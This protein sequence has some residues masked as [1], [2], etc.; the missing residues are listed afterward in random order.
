MSDAA[1]FS[2]SG[3]ND[4]GRRVTNRDEPRLR[5]VGSPL[6]AG[7]PGPSSRPP[8]LGDERRLRTAPPPP[9]ALVNMAPAREQASG[10]QRAANALRAALPLVQRIL[11]LLDGN[12]GTAVSNVLAPYPQMHQLPPPVDLEPLED[13]LAELQMQHRAL[14]NQFLEQNASLKRVEDQLEAVRETAERNSREQEELLDDLKTVRRR[15]N[16]FAIP[17]LGLLGLSVLLNV[18]LY[19]HMRHILP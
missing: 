7:L 9:R 5:V 16:R 3:M 12:I 10:L 13:G 11:P 18:L 17:A 19:L 6:P 14:R 2:A 15:V 1:G 8:V 4:P